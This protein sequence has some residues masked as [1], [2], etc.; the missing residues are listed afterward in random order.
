MVNPH[1]T[2]RAMLQRDYELALELVRQQGVRICCDPAELE[3]ARRTFLHI[4][5][6]FFPELLCS[7]L[8]LV[9]IYDMDEQPPALSMCDGR[10]SISETF[11]DGR[12]VASIGIS[13][14]AL[15]A[16]EDYSILILLH[17]LTHVLSGFPSEHGPEFHAYLDRLVE[18]Y[19]LE[20]RSSI[21]NDYFGMPETP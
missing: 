9:Y 18:R 19:N 20:T 12:Q 8:S 21:V 15:H 5:K 4:T 6:T 3:L 17:E 7:C 10:A 13:L 16:G 11:P 2:D 14:Q 1:W